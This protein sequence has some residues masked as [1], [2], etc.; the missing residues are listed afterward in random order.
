[1]KTYELLLHLGFNGR[2]QQT[3]LLADAIDF[4]IDNFDKEVLIVKDVY[5]TVGRKNGKTIKTVE[6]QIYR[7]IKRAWPNAYE[8]L[9]NWFS[10]CSVSK[11]STNGRF[12]YTMAY[13]II[14]NYI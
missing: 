8:F 3:R 11:Q 5:A 13:L 7:A 4:V 2:N 6:Q 9:Q 1:M 14:N 10:D 12:I